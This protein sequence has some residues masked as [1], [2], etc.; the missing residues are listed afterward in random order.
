MPRRKS[1][2]TRAVAL[3]E[4]ECPICKM[5]YGRGDK[6]VRTP[7][8]HYFHKECLESWRLIKNECPLDHRQLPP[9]PPNPFVRADLVDF[10]TGVWHDRPPAESVMRVNTKHRN[11]PIRLEA[12][13]VCGTGLI[14]S[15]RSWCGNRNSV[16]AA[17]DV[18]S[19]GA[20]LQFFQQV[21]VESED[22]WY[23]VNY[24]EDDGG[25]EMDSNMYELDGDDLCAEF[26][27]KFPV[28]VAYPEL[29]NLMA[30]Y[31]DEHSIAWHIVVDVIISTHDTVSLFCDFNSA[32]LRIVKIDFDDHADQL[33]DADGHALIASLSMHPSLWKVGV[34]E[35]EVTRTIRIE[36]VVGP[37]RQK[38][39]EAVHPRDAF[40]DRV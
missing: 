34:N 27:A 16:H 12:V 24:R 40:I 9:L 38:L 13:V 28:G 33:S 36:E 29:L 26:D 7:C 15:M 8:N 20:L 3:N 25:V 17:T 4:D 6:I 1:K 11:V 10:M 14:R 37:L 32:T 21:D 35:N 23:H 5:D 2:A 30:T 39:Y 22:I 31:E 19:E 18:F